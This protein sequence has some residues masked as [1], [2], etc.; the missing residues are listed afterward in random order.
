[1]TRGVAVR[2]AVLGAIG[3]ALL[4]VLFIRLWFLQVIGSE[5]YAERAEGNRIRTVVVESERG[6]ITDRNGEVLVAN[7]PSRDLVARPGELVGPQ[8]AEVVQRLAPVLGE[9]PAELRRRLDEGEKT[10]YQSVLLAED[11]PQELELYLAERQQSFPGIS[12]KDTFTREYPQ[13]P[14]AA[15]ILGYTGAITEENVGSYRDEGYQGN[16]RVGVAGVESQYE[17]FLRGSPGRVEVEVDASGQPVGRGVVDSVAPRPGRNV[18]LSIDLDTQRA[19]E[20]ALRTQVDLSGLAE[21]A[22]GVALDPRTGEVLAIA[23]Y[24]TFNPLVFAENKPAE[25]RKIQRNPLDPLVNRAITGLYPVG[26]TFKAV[27]A[28]AALESGVLDRG[29]FIGSP[30]ELELYK[31][32]FRNFGF[33]SHGDI[34]LPVALEVSSDTFFYTLG[35]RFFERPDS[36]LQEWAEKFGFGALTGIDLPGEAAGIVPT[37]QWKREAFAG[38]QFGEIDRIWKPG[39]TIQLTVGQGFLQATPLQLAAA[40]G[41]IANDGRVVKPTIARRIVGASGR[42]ERSIIAGGSDEPLGTSPQT[43]DT[44]RQGLFQAANGDL[45]TATPVFFQMPDGKEV[46]GKTGTAEAP[47]GE[48]HSWFVG[49]A[50]ADD[51]Q[52]VVAVVIERGGTGASAAAPVVCKTVSANL[53]TP[54]EQCGSGAQSN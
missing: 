17:Q 29:E 22:A 2:I 44:I 28:A 40:Y 21:G 31:Q 24:P 38:N 27:T 46:A 6:L 52:I 48:D 7:K 32:K 53:R 10:P 39:D 26:S 3:L 37:P 36:K 23:S 12:L 5:Q 8:R 43:L 18:E 50:P 34:T 20:E 33:A 30:G 47:P 51:P 9:R 1:L 4:S 54:I 41:A 45:G 15:H 11:V 16:E 49:Y 42:Q 19:L 25:L 13:G 35:S 14:A